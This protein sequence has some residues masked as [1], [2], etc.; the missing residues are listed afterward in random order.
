MFIAEIKETLNDNLLSIIIIGTDKLK[1]YYTLGLRCIVG[2]L[3]LRCCD[4]LT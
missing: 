2:F 3:W 1:M 4:F